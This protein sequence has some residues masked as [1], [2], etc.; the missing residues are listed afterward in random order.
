M[1]EGI[2]NGIRAV[3]TEAQDSQE[4]AG[5]ETGKAKRWKKRWK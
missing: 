1:K 2:R 5:N 3:R 4:K